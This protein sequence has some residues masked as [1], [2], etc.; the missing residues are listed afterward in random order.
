MDQSCHWECQA[1]NGTTEGKFCN[2]QGTDMYMQGFTAS[3]NDKDACVILLFKSWVLDTRTKFGFGCVGVI[4]LGIAI[5]GMLCLRREL[6]SRKI[7]LR[8]SGVARRVLIVVL[9]TLNIASGYLAMLVAMTYSVELFICMV[10]GL[11]VGHAIF[12]TGAAV[13]E[14]VDPCCASQA[15][16]HTND[17]KQREAENTCA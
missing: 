15:I 3:G 1:D 17:A 11:V 6:Q 7:L 9:F 8:I 12:N 2:G 16:S 14:S 10:V 5:E 13:G 4:L